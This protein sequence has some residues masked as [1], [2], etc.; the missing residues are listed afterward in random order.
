MKTLYNFLKIHEAESETIEPMVDLCVLI[1][2]HFY[3]KSN[4]TLKI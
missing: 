1:W 3:A 2:L 4:M